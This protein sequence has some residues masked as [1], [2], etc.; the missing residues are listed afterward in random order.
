MCILACLECCSQA[1]AETK[2]LMSDPDPEMNSLAN[3]EFKSLQQS[4]THLTSHTFPSLLVP[5]SPTSGLSA[6]L[7]LQAGVGGTEA[8]LFLEDLLRMYTRYANSRAWETR[9][10]NRDNDDGTTMGG[11]MVE[12]SGEGAYDALRWE[13]GVHRIQRV[14][15]TETSGR[16]HTSTVTVAVSGSEA[17]LRR[18]S[19]IP[20][21]PRSSLCL[22]ITT[23][24]LNP[25][26][27]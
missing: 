23:L 11:V 5:S 10:L 8:C 26:M 16:M 22:D 25:C 18:Y 14:P 24:D 21:W 6:V 1:V 3:E 13:S 2:V 12:V 27:I 4:L 17:T 7:E 15:V 9:V 20:C 19:L